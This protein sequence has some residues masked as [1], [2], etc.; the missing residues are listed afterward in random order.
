ML[1]DGTLHGE[2][3][4]Q[5]CPEIVMP[6]ALD[7]IATWAR[8]TNEAA[9]CV[10]NHSYIDLVVYYVLHDGEQTRGCERSRGPS[11]FPFSL[12]IGSV[13]ANHEPILPRPARRGRAGRLC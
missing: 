1:Q 12:A 13:N 2:A 11:A 9:H 10:T 3:A 4:G 6:T 8:E 5:L 7:L